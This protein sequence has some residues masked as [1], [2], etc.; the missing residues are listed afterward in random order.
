MYFKK[1]YSNFLS[2]RERGYKCSTCLYTYG[3]SI[4]VQEIFHLCASAKTKT[5]SNIKNSLEHK[6]EEKIRD[7]ERLISFRTNIFTYK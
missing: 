2:A 5:R 3:D 6:K 1:I 4:A 7:W